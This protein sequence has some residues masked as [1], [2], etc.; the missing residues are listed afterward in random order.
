MVNIQTSNVAQNQRPKHQRT[1]TINKSDQSGKTDLGG[2]VP[3]LGGVR[4]VGE[5]GMRLVVKRKQR[6]HFK[7]GVPH[8]H[9]SV[10]VSGHWQLVALCQ[11]AQQQSRFTS[12]PRG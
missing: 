2:Y 3:D 6:I 8:D 1:V 10:E 5:S 4:S 12:V 11:H 7:E 9:K